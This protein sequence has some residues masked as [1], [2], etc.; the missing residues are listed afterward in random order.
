MKEPN[1][2]MTA[3]VKV[4]VICDI[5]FYHGIKNNIKRKI[6][7]AGYKNIKVSHIAEPCPQPPPSLIQLESLHLSQK[8]DDNL[9]YNIGEPKSPSGTPISAAS[10]NTLLP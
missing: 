8:K 7:A 1:T 5:L 4:L 2:V 6:T 9:A 10:F 3:I